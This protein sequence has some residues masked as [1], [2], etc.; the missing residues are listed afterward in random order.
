[1]SE[2]FMIVHLFEAAIQ[3]SLERFHLDDVL[4]EIGGPERGAV[5]QPATYQTVEK[6]HEQL[7]CH[8]T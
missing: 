4:L 2:T 5:L 8:E 3:T 6:S 7:F 1:M